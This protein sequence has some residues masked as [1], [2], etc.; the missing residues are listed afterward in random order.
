MLHVWLVPL[1]AFLVVALWIA[2]LLVKHRGGDGV[3]TTGRCLI[4]DNTSDEDCPP[5]FHQ[6]R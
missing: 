3:R 2:Y 6:A 1:L 4:E 5:Q